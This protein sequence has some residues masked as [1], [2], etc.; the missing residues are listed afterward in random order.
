MVC[1][2][3]YRGHFTAVTLGERSRLNYIVYLWIMQVVYSGKK[4][5]GRR[6]W[7]EH[8]NYKHCFYVN[9]SFR[10]YSVLSRAKVFPNEVRKCVILVRPSLW[11][12]YFWPVLA[13]IVY[14]RCLLVF[15]F[16]IAMLIVNLSFTCVF[17]YC[18]LRFW[19]IVLNSACLL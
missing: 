6:R 10:C 8:L 2:F 7:K 11:P 15:L 5:R 16:L 18:N 17:D 4:A 9:M 14:S 13:W 3:V 19:I 12:L 1:H